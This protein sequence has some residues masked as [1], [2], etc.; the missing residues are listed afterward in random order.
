VDTHA[1]YT[2]L[3]DNYLQ[4]WKWV[5][6]QN[7]EA[8]GGGQSAFEYMHA[9]RQQAVAQLQAE[10]FPHERSSSSSKKAALTTAHKV[11][12]SSDGGCAMA[13]VRLPPEIRSSAVIRH[14][15]DTADGIASAAA[16]ST[17]AKSVQDWLYAQKI[18]VPTKCVRGE[19]YLRISAHVHNEIADYERL[20]AAIRSL[21]IGAQV[22]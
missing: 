3:K 4:F 19:L 1:A 13:L 22:R 16:D 7:K 21:C 11:N 5:D 12:A 9:L 14:N 2:A 20:S 15:S 8:D 6:E 17:T 18:E 10:W